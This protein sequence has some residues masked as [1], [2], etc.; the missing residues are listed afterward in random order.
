MHLVGTLSTFLSRLCGGEWHT[1]EGMLR[2][3]CI[4]QL[5]PKAYSM[6]WKPYQDVMLEELAAM[7]KLIDGHVI[8]YRRELRGEAEEII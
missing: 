2:Y 8:S 3:S 5:S 4:H 1:V 7:C 6:T